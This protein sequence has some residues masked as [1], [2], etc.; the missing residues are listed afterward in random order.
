MKNNRIFLHNWQGDPDD[1]FIDIPWPLIHKVVGSGVI[2]WLN[3]KDPIEVQ[4][5]LD[6]TSDGWQTLWAE[7]YD[8]KIQTEF[9]LKFDK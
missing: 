4:M 5:I 3:R 7:F 2:A 1:Q 9:Y 6:K 8:E